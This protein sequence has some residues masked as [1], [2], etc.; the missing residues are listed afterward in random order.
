MEFHPFLLPAKLKPITV[1]QPILL[2]KSLNFQQIGLHRENFYGKKIMKKFKKFFGSSGLLAVL[3]N[4]QAFAG[5]T[6]GC[7]QGQQRV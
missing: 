5:T 3:Y 6:V 1:A 7:P 4:R 2:P